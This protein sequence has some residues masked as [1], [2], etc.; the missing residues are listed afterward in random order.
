MRNKINVLSL[1]TT[2]QC[3]WALCKSR[4]VRNCE[5]YMKDM[6]L[7]NKKIRIIKGATKVGDMMEIGIH[8][9]K[10]IKRVKVLLPGSTKS[11]PVP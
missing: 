4:R 5:K 11:C 3:C 1:A 8:S 6:K 7:A 2:S 10:W 9:T